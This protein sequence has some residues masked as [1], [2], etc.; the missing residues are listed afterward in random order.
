VKIRD[1]DTTVDYQTEKRLK[2]MLEELEDAL[3]GIA[4]LP[5]EPSNGT[6]FSREAFLLLQG[7]QEEVV[8]FWRAQSKA[9]FEAAEGDL[10]RRRLMLQHN[11]A[12][13]WEPLHT[14]ASPMWGFEDAFLIPPGPSALRAKLFGLL[15]E[16]LPMTG[17]FDAKVFPEELGEPSRLLVSIAMGDAVALEAVENTA[18]LMEGTTP[19][20]EARLRGEGALMLLARGPLSMSGLTFARKQWER[21]RKE[22]L[23][24]ISEQPLETLSS[25][26]FYAL[27]N[28][29]I[30]TTKGFL[31]RCLENQDALPFGRELFRDLV[32]DAPEPISAQCWSEAC[33]KEP[34]LLD[35]PAK[36]GAPFTLAGP[37]GCDPFLMALEAQRLVCGKPMFD[38]WASPS[39]D[40]TAVDDQVPKWIEALVNLGMKKIPAD[41]QRLNGFSVKEV[42]AVQRWALQEDAWPMAHLS[43]ETRQ[44]L[45]EWRSEFATSLGKVVA[46]PVAQKTDQEY[47]EVLLEVGLL[48][49]WTPVLERPKPRF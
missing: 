10:I 13:L 31:E 45:N 15:P 19:A 3:E 17:E 40:S 23:W 6:L 1:Q 16:D 47:R 43:A 7:S 38:Q 25:D 46:F 32:W 14:V 27:R 22:G 44:Q 39:F 48:K 29:R 18:W 12:D 20:E 42:Q 33:F 21:A 24:E 8:A 35:L 5:T 41:R 36:Q 4:G 2:K 30:A 26:V 34:K 9:Y 37:D 49:A 11:R 28:E